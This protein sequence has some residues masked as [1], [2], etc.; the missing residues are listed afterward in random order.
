[1][2]TVFFNFGLHAI[3]INACKLPYGPTETD[4]ERKEKKPAL[5]GDMVRTDHVS[6]KSRLKSM[7][8]RGKKK[9]NGIKK[10]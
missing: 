7:L 3:K 9:E 4:S 5:L 2:L 8:L 1:M 6:E 10:H